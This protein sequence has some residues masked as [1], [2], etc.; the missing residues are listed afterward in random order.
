MHSASTCIIHPLLSK[1]NSTHP[2]VYLPSHQCIVLEFAYMQLPSAAAP[3][4]LQ[5]VQGAQLW[6]KPLKTGHVEGWD[7]N[8][9]AVARALQLAE[10]VRACASWN[11][12]GRSQAK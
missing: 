12:G 1:S 6:Y 5:P 11:A 8:V 3:N 10:Q 7:A 4:T 9:V 2:T